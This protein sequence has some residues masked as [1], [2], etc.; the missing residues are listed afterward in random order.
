MNILFTAAMSCGQCDPSFINFAL[1]EKILE[2][3][4]IAEKSNDWLQVEHPLIQTL[5]TQLDLSS[6]P[7]L[8]NR[9]NWENFT[10]IPWDDMTS[11]DF[12]LF[13]L[14]EEDILLVGIYIGDGQFIHFSSEKNKINIHLHNLSDSD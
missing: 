6:H 3:I 2:P 5:A 12:I 10:S 8:K 11:D 1:Q 4:Q 13:G 9:N 14:T 7:H